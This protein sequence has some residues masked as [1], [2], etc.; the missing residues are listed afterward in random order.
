MAVDV[1]LLSGDQ[2]RSTFRKKAKAS[3]VVRKMGRRETE[4][5]TARTIR[6]KSFKP[7]VVQ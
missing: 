6:E 5:I 4:M 1:Q 2:S 7:N 3:V